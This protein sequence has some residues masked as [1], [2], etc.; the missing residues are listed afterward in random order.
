MRPHFFSIQPAG[1]RAGTPEAGV[2]PGTARYRA[3]AP[4]ERMKGCRALRGV[5]Y[6]P[7]AVGV[8]F[9]GNAAF[10]SKNGAFAPETL[11][12]PEDVPPG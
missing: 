3:E 1:A 4:I 9:C 6:E 5:G 7:E 10:A 12:M 8:R 2:V 11:D